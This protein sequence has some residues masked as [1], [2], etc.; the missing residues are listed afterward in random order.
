[1]VYVH[2]VTEERSDGEDGLIQG[3]MYVNHTVLTELKP[4]FSV[5]SR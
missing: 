4:T 5:V 3:E 2:E 1:M